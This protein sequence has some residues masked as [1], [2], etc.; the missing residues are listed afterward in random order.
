MI[1]WFKFNGI[2]LKS[3]KVDQWG[4]GTWSRSATILIVKLQAKCMF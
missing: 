2:S 3:G 1:L 4:Y